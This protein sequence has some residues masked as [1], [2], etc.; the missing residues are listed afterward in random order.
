MI[1]H[2]GMDD[3][4]KQGENEPSSWNARKVDIRKD[5]RPLGVQDHPGP[6]L[7]KSRYCPHGNVWGRCPQ[8]C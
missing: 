1:Y 4:P 5:V 2:A 6:T 7:K 8:G 3:K